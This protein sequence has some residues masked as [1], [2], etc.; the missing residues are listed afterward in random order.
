MRAWQASNIE[1]PALMHQRWMAVA[2]GLALTLS[3][4]LQAQTQDPRP[5]ILWLTS[6]DNG[7]HLGCYGDDYAT[8][9]NLDKLSE[10]GVRYLNAWSNAP[11]CAPARTT[12]I[13]GMYPT[14]LGA[15][16]MRSLTRLPEDFRMYPQYLRDAG[17]YC[18]N[19]SKEDYNL[20]KPGKV[21]DESSPRAHW[22]NR[23]PG[24]PF[25]AVFNFTVT[26]ES[27][28]RQRPHKAVHDPA[29]VRIP[30]YHPD[31]PEVRQDWAQY[32]DKITEMDELAGQRLQE[33]Q[34]AGLAD[35][36]I[37]FY[38]GDHGSGMPRNKRWPYNS[39]LRVPLIV[40]IPEKFQHLASP[41]YKVG[42][43][44]T[45]LVSFVDFAPTL[46][47]LAGI[48]PPKHFQGN[49]FLG[50]YQKPEQKYLFGFRGRMDERLDLVRSV[51]NHR[52]V[53]V[54]NFMP[55]KPYGQ[56][57]EYMF[58]TPTTRVWKRLYD[59]GKLNEAQSHFW[60]EKPPEELYDLQADPDE[61]NNLA[62]SPEH[63][64]IKAE[65]R[66]A[67]ESW[68]LQTRDAG[69]LPEHE[70]HSRSAGTAPYQ[71]AQSQQKYPLEQIFSTALAASSLDTK[72]NE[73]LK[74]D[75]THEDSAVRYWAV[76]G[77]FM[78]GEKSVTDFREDI[79]AL[80]NDEAASVAIVAAEALGQYGTPEDL[81]ASLEVLLKYANVREQGIYLSI[82]ALNAIDGLG[83]KAASIRG[84]LEK[85]P[86]KDPK[87]PNRLSSYSDRLLEKILADLSSSG[88]DA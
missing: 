69:F 75:L 24:Q 82:S 28:I 86:R 71:M 59:E 53:Y 26:H 58:Q 25:F 13:A 34:E 2:L 31:A 81:A 55:H 74:A 70:I 27:Q 32:Y 7:P 41:D 39:G 38:Y 16:H 84:E 62:D 49:A 43:A 23:K 48:E 61:V 80:L 8:T 19:N 83:A 46:L 47:S 42:A 60:K 11:V 54:R 30:A 64:Q 73:K 67:L 40:V 78:R 68:I 50:S 9:P 66:Q 15:E 22:K 14:C 77:L 88:R 45:R 72:Q 29:K 4:P 65:L 57:L 35:D 12:L 79:K 76:L 44:S 52:Y 17:Y 63:Q 56:Y 33:L 36:T 5:N 10:R 21:W 51:R 6:E 20:E 37:I 1:G 18:T 3:A 87:L 85:L